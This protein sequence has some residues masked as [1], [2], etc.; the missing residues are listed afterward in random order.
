MTGPDPVV[1]RPHPAVTSVYLPPDGVLYDER[2]GQVYRLNPSAAAVWMLL[3]GSA[4]VDAVAAEIST[5]FEVPVEQVRPDVQTAVDQFA[6][7]GLLMRD[8][9]LPEPAQNRLRLP[10]RLRLSSVAPPVEGEIA[11]PLPVFTRGGQ[12]VLLHRRSGEPLDGGRLQ[13]AGV[14]EVDGTWAFVAP[15]GRSVAVGRL[16]WPLRTVLVSDEAA[17]GTDTDVALATAR[18]LLW[19]LARGDRSGWERLLGSQGWVSVA[20]GD[21]E[22]AL[23]AA[24]A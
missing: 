3:D 6:G 19:P 8:G 7:Q 15:D 23:E 14:A 22:A 24:L 4:D 9:D 20:G 12:A 21:V 10:D 5:V 17:A 18:G 13:Q 2:T 11:V 16:R 1:P